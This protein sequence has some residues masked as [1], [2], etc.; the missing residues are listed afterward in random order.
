MFSKGWDISHANL[1]IQDI[2][3]S[4]YM[5]RDLNV[6]RAE[7]RVRHRVRS[8]LFIRDFIPPN[9][10]GAEFGVFTGLFSSI[11][12]REQRISQ[13]TFIDPWW[14]AYGDQFPDWGAYTDYGRINTRTAF[15]IAKK[16][17]L[18]SGLPNRIV[19]VATS[20]EWLLNQSDNS[21][22]WV[23]I[24][25]THSYDGTKRELELL[26]VKLKDTG[27]ILGDDWQFDRSNRHHGVCLAVNEFLKNSSFEL[28]LCGR[29]FQW[30]LRRSLPDKSRLPIFLKDP[31]G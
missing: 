13:V 15:D 25:S 1:M 11:F 6:L 5:P 14:K 31:A 7:L 2:L 3:L 22:D 9:S 8:R 4:G 30:I 29:C 17:I 27:L 21:L 10:I 18:R 20:S 24:D 26:N 12:A 16:R 23:Y 28:I 19:E